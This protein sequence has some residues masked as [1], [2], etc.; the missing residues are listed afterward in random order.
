MFSR[1]TGW[2]GRQGICAI[3]GAIAGAFTGAIFGLWLAAMTHSVLVGQA[4]AVGLVLGLIAWMGILFLLLAMG[5]Y[6]LS[7]V[8]IPSLV[9]C[10]VASVVTALSVNA[11]HHPDEGV[12]MGWILGFLIGRLFCAACKRSVATAIGVNR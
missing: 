7:S 5:H 11:V 2:L 1:L 8:L 4:L 12:L 9:T 6:S 10:V 3:V